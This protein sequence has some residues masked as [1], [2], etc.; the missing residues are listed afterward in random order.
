MLRRPVPTLPG[1]PPGL[2]TIRTAEHG[3]PARPVLSH[4]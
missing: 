2:A 4:G 3:S 1:L